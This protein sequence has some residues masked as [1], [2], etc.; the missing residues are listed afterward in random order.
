MV[1]DPS[2]SPQLPCSLPCLSSY[3]T[4][5]PPATTKHTPGTTIHPR[6]LNLA[7]SSSPTSRHRQQHRSDRSSTARVTASSSVFFLACSPAYLSVPHSRP[8]PYVR[9]SNTHQVKSKYTAVDFRY[10]ISVL[11]AWFISP[12]GRL[13][14]EEQRCA[15][16]SETETVNVEGIP[17]PA[18]I[19]VGNPLSLLGTGTSA[20]SS[21]SFQPCIQ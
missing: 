3:L 2:H 16:G 10:I 14:D 15:V 9:A 19:T 6:A 17:F 5:P 20:R 8:L 7:S 4:S 18:E 1:I 12:Y 11:H 13:C 21:S